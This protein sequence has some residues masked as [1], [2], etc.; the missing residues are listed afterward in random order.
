[1]QRRRGLEKKFKEELSDTEAAETSR[2]Q[3]YDMNMIQLSDLISHSNADREAKA[4]TKATRAAE[5][6]K[7]KGDLA[8]TK[9]ALA[10]DEKTLAEMTSTF[11]QK[12]DVFKQNLEVRKLEL[13]A[14]AKAIE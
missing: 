6:A 14:L 3:N 9:T 12:S 13:E 1:M 5:S 8:D 11:E 2:V 10:A 4:E 7:A